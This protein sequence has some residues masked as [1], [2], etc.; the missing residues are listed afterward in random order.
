MIYC[1]KLKKRIELKD[2]SNCKDKG[3]TKTKDCQEW[4][5]DILD[6]TGGQEDENT[7]NKFKNYW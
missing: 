4:N 5:I 1:K 7:T 6:I 2:C 3:F